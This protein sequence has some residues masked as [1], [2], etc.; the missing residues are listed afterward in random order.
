V[1]LD[2]LTMAMRKQ[3]QGGFRGRKSHRHQA[4]L[5]ALRKQLGITT[6]QELR[7]RAIKTAVAAV[8]GHKP[9]AA[10]LLGIGKTTLY[11]HW[12]G[13]ESKGRART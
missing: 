10:E 1:T 12:Q 13:T 8:K 4:R 7:D 11:R 2:G 3:K 9:L 6:L 5:A